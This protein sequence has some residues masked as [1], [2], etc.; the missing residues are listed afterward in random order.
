ML[1]LVSVLRRF[2]ITCIFSVIVLF[3]FCSEQFIFEQLSTTEGLSSGTVNTIFKDSRGFMWFSTD[4]GLNRF[5]GYTF[6]V[7]NPAEKTGKSD[8]SLQF[9]DIVEDCYGTLWLGTSDGLFFFD[10]D[11]EKIVQFI[12][13]T[14]IFLP[15]NLLNGSINAVFYDSRNYLWVGTY[16]GVV[17]IKT[18]ENISQ[19]HDDNI[20]Y[21]KALPL[22]TVKL[23]TM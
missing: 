17:R 20:T 11:D 15:E 4:D 3:S 16:N 23:I 5:D 7:Y 6:K 1:L 8:K 13:S 12:D 19:I 9:L 10:R 14:K 18:T 22:H 2:F 21:F